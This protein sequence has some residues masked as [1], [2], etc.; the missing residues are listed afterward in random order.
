MTNITVYAPGHYD[1]ADSYGL[2]ACQLAR[3]LTALGVHVNAVG[4]GETV[5]DNQPEDVRAVT[6]RP[7]R[8]S[9]GGLA[10]GYA[11]GFNRYGA[12]LHAGPRIAIT[13]FESSRC[14]A[15][16]VQPLN[17]M[18][19][20]ITPSWFCAEVF[21]QCGVTVPVHVVPLGVGEVYRYAERPRERPLT[22]LAFMDRGARKGGIT[23]LQAFLMAFGEDMNY[24]LIL[25][26]RKA[27]VP[28]E[29]TNPNITVIH[30]DMSEAEL[31]EL[32]LSADVLI[33]AHRGEGFGLLPREF[34]ATGGI[35]MTTD[36]SGTADGLGVWGYPLPYELVKADWRGNKSLEG[37]DLGEW[38]EVSPERV[39][40]HLRI[41]AAN[42]EYYQERA[43]TAAHQAVNLYSWRTFAEQVLSIWKEACI[44]YSQ[45]AVAA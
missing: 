10:L 17:E 40:T 22:F 25:K 18:D 38:A 43:K 31:Y 3:H 24:R 27:K 45:R 28:L 2:I 23:A 35:A 21:R 29:F 41:V 39:A 30:Q 7:L 16:W 13:M 15:S 12:L 42:R 37:Q 26:S 5:M 14:P 1:I 9:L 33:N 19:A 36:W 32:Y 8:P 34:A 44:G 4:L 11:T 20:V 6:S